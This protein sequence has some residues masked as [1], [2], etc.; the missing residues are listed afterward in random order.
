MKF[1][2]IAFIALIATATTKSTNTKGCASCYSTCSKGGDCAGS[3]ICCSG[4]KT[5]SG[6]DAAAGTK[7]CVPSAGDGTVPSTVT[8]PYSGF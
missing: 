3:F 6:T 1:A 2:L 4:T 8:T 5:K 7:L